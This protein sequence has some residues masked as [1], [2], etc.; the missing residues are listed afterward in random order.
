MEQLR[1]RGPPCDFDCCRCRCCIGFRHSS[2]LARPALAIA[3][4]LCAHLASRLRALR[5]RVF[6]YHLLMTT[7]PNKIAAGN[8]GWRFQFRFAVHAFWSLVPELWPLDPWPR[9][10]KHTHI[11]WSVIVSCV[12]LQSAFGQGFAN[13]NFEQATIVSAPSGYTPWDAYDALL[14]S[15]ALPYWT[16][17]EDG[18]VCTAVWGAPVALDETSVALLTA[19][20]GYYSGY[21]PLQGSYSIQFYVY[22]DA[23]SSCFHTA[24][25]SQT[26]QIP[27][28]SHSIQFLMMSPPVA[29]GVIQASPIVTINGTPIGLSPISTSGGV[30]TMAGDISAYAGTAVDLTILCQ[31]TPGSFPANENIFTLDSIQFSPQSVPEPSSLELLCIGAAFVCL[32]AKHQWRG[33]DDARR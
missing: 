16:V 25:I 8:A 5:R 3:D 22:A 21:V 31:A 1:P 12:L 28:G 2:F 30:M 10:M 33:V 26:G 9:L 20:N 7:Q 23:P 18:T 14:A 11:I 24:S 17:R 32:H 29:G 4:C 19:N 15:S 6:G 13:L 27:L